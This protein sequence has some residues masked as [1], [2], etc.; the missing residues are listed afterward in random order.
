[1]FNTARTTTPTNL[2]LLVYNQSQD[3]LCMQQAWRDL[4][5]NTQL[6]LDSNNK[7]TMPD[8]FGRCIQVYDDPTGTGKPARYYYLGHIDPCQRYTEETTI[9]GTTGARTI[10]FCFPSNVSI[11]NPY[12]TY[13][14]ALENATEADVTGDTKLSF[15][16]INIMLCVAKK[17]LMRYYGKSANQD[18]KQV[19][20]DIKEELDLLKRYAY[21]NNAP[22]DI[23]VTD[24]NGNPVYITGVALD[25]S[26][27]RGVNYP[28]SNATLNLR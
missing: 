24:S 15:F 2:G 26:G 19:L 5:V 3:W 23:S 9:N 18:I 8:D 4:A 10:K 13:S 20:F 6:T 12:V 7:I 25:G 14:K 16:P 27:Y 1:M 11:S 21:T 22:L 28:Y 17:M